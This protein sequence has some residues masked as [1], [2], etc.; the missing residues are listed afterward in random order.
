M[1]TGELTKEEA[2]AL[3]LKASTEMALEEQAT[4]VVSILFY[5]APGNFNP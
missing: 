4:R 1:P 2:L 5:S 3:T